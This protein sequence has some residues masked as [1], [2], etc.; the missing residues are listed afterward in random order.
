VRHLLDE[1]RVLQALVSRA[2]VHAQE[3]QALPPA[4]EVESKTEVRLPRFRAPLTAVESVQVPRI[5]WP[6]LRF[7]S[8]RGRLW[9][10]TLAGG[11]GIALLLIF[12]L[13]YLANPRTASRVR[14]VSPIERLRIPV[15][16]AATLSL[17][18]LGGQSWVLVE[19]LAG[20]QVHDSILD[21]GES[22]VLPLCTGLRV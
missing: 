10:L 4:L 12:G 18:A 3:R 21:S 1:R 6:S 16:P 15:S 19:S 2:L 17:Q 7:H 8:S 20:G 22:K 5:S 9:A 13:Q 14:T 11:F